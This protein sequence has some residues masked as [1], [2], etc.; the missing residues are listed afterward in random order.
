MIYG[1]DGQFGSGKTSFAVFIANRYQGENVC[2]WTNAKLNTVLIKNVYYFE[3][4]DLLGALRS[5]NFINDVERCFNGFETE[6]NNLVRWHRHKFTR[7]ILI[8]DEAG[9]IANGRDSKNFDNV[10]TE[11]VNQN[12]K[13][14]MDIYIVTAD[15]GQAEK[16]LRRFVD[17]WFY[18]KPLVSWLPILKDFK[19]VRCQKRDKDGVKVQMEE[20][21][22]Q[23]E[24][25]DWI[26]KQRPLDRFETVYFQPMVFNLYDD[27]YKNIKDPMKYQGMILPAIRDVVLRKKYYDKL[28]L[29]LKQLVSS[30]PLDDV[31]PAPQI[32]E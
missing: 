6:S 10:I 29:P 15:G 4:D 8:F 20:Y 9:A 26:M 23:D 17:W 3:D 30:N 24:Q 16:S 18:S 28:P 14:F 11:Y 5:V 2:I 25:G 22:A 1:I 31:L 27:L 13:E 19:H 21:L 32:S 7:H 12:R